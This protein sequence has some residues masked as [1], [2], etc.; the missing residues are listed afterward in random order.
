MK[1]TLLGSELEARRNLNLA[2]SRKWEVV[3]R[4]AKNHLGASSGYIL[5]PEENGVPYAAPR[6][7]AAEACRFCQCALLG[8]RLRSGATAK[9]RVSTR[10]KAG[11]M[12]ACPSGHGQTGPSRTATL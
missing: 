4:S 2:S 5:V 9:P 8:H 11:A 10:T 1:E 6:L 12:T 3:N 7:M